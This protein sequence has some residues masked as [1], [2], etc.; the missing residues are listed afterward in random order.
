MKVTIRSVD[1]KLWEEAKV[2]CARSKTLSLG[3][4]VNEGLALRELVK[5]EDIRKAMETAAEQKATRENED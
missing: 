4:I 5:D 1:P 2:E 3:K